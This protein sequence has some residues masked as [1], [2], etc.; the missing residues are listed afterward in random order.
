MSVLYRE[1]GGPQVQALFEQPEPIY[2][3]FIAMM[4][5]Q[6][7]LMREFPQELDTRMALVASWPI[8]VVESDPQWRELAAIVK[9]PGR[10]ST[11]DAWA[12]ALA[13]QN[14]AV[15]VHKDP[16]FEKVADLQELRLPY[17]P[18]GQR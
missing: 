17:K 9:A 8:N 10:I 7:K 14:D 12:A 3:P 5:V 15:L 13:L 1:D 6:Y 16:E 11:A 18:R 4:E 2:V